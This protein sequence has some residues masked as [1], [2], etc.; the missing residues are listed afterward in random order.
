MTGNRIS[1]SLIYWI[2]YSIVRRTLDRE[3]TWSTWTQGVDKRAIA[4]SRMLINIIF[5]HG[6][7]LSF[8][9]SFKF[10]DQVEINQGIQ[11]CDVAV[12]TPLRVA[13]TTTADRR[14]AFQAHEAHTRDARP[15]LPDPRQCVMPQG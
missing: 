10:P 8:V 14:V 15:A 13:V 6:Q 2:V 4:L 9:R 12:E 7:Y 11:E 3:S 5:S 1:Y